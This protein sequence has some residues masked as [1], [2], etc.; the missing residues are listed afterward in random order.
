VAPVEEPLAG[1]NVADSVVRVGDTV[2]KPWI[3]STPAVHAFL[4]HLAE[5]GFAG[6]PRAHGRDERG[7]QILDFV[8]GTNAELLPWFTDDQLYRLGAM[9][10]ELHDASED[11]V[12][13]ADARWTV[14]I[15]ADGADLI[16]HQDLAPWNLIR[17]GPTGEQP[18]SRLWYEGHG[19]HWAGAAEYVSAHLDA[20][21]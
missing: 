14:A 17:D 20:W 16:C 9:V 1:G 18:W 15:P 12:P 11:F 7:R 19:P 8:P 6:A 21:S 4:E 13:P 10:R 3:A 5:R 2:R